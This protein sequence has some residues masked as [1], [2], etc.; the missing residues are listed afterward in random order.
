MAEADEFAVDPAEALR[1]SEAGEAKLIDVRT[2]HEWDAG[3]IPGAVHV[4]LNDLVPRAE[5]LEGPLVFYCR[6]GR[7]SDM[8]A[9]AFREAGRD[10][11]R[12]EGGIEAWRADGLPLEP[13]EGYVAESGDAAAVLEERRR[14]AGVDPREP[15]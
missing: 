6:A 7:R 8:A 10:A 9:A 3:H 1:R 15:W 4:E 12:M 11:I 5:E 14:E 13:A 2:A